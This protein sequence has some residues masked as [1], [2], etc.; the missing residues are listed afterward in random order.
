MDDLHRLGDLVSDHSASRVL[1]AN[2]EGGADV[3]TALVARAEHLR[4]RNNPATA[5]LGDETTRTGSVVAGTS[6]GVISA[7]ANSSKSFSVYTFHR[8]RSI[9]PTPRLFSI[10]VI[11]YGPAHRPR[12]RPQRPAARPSR[13]QYRT[14]RRRFRTKRRRRG[15]TIPD[16]RC[17]PPR[18]PC[19]S[20]P[21][22]P[23][24]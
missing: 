20:A 8:Q 7:C 1:T 5:P 12:R 11:W 18:F 9:R 21:C 19:R 24:P 16:K 17:T 23:R 15:S 22:P 6:V 3:A 4:T 13:P 14:A 10:L 2:A